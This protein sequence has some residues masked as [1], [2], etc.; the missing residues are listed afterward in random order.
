MKKMPEENAKSLLN[1][2][3]TIGKLKGLKRTGWVERGVS[4]PE[5]VAEHAFRMSAMAL[6]LAP[7][8]KCDSEKLVK[9]CI[10]HDLHESISGDLILDWKR[11]GSS[12]KGLNKEE[13]AMREKKAFEELLEILG[14]KDSR[15]F[16]KLWL[17]FEQQKT[18]E[19]KIAR[20]L[21]VLEMLLQAAE[22]E[23]ADN[24]AEK[25]PVWIPWI[26]AHSQS[27]KNPEL[28]KILEEIKKE[29]AVG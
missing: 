8:L 19:A 22:Y 27:I 4:N 16:K 20:E 28:R 26:T 1:F 10:V 23:K 12:Y 2:F 13:K 7:K 3:E 24:H 15:E 18:G 21:D 5:S 29:M 6:V 11:H 25:K 17:E 14:K 9:M